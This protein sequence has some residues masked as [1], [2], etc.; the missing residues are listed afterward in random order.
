MQGCIGLRVEGIGMYRV[1][2]LGL[3]VKGCTGF[4]VEGTGMYR[5]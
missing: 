3:R 1:W 5:V 4:R 2:D